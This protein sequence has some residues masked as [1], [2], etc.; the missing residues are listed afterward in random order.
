MAQNMK[1]G[2]EEALSEEATR[3]R[4]S[5]KVQRKHQGTEHEGR[6]IEGRYREEAV[7][8][9]QKRPRGTEDETRYRES[10]Q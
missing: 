8:C 10:V 6:H 9:V 1:Q 7:R 2:S 5:I 3:F 4:G